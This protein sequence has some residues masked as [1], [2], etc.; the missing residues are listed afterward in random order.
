MQF[1]LFSTGHGTFFAHETFF[2]LFVFLL[3]RSICAEKT[4]VTY[5]YISFLR[6]CKPGDRRD[7]GQCEIRLRRR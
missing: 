5:A 7:Y 3:K 6:I 2:I 4:L 1:F